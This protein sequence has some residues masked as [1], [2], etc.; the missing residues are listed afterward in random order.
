MARSRALTIGLVYHDRGCG[1]T[2]AGVRL[3]PDCDPGFDGQGT[4][5]LRRSFSFAQAGRGLSEDK[6]SRGLNSYIYCAT[7]NHA[8]GGMRRGQAPRQSGETP[9][10]FHRRAVH[11]LGQRDHPGGH[12]LRLSRAAIL[13]VRN[14]QEAASSGG[15][16]RTRRQHSSHQLPQSECKGGQTRWQKNVRP[17]MTTFRR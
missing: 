2:S 15:I 3:P 17:T 16:L 11:G 8:A 13:G 10:G 4:P 5:C 12:P 7:L 1:A 9:R 6:R 14:A